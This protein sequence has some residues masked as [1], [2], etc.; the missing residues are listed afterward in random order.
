[1]SRPIAFVKRLVHRAPPLQE[2]ASV[3]RDDD[4]VLRE[5]ISLE[6]SVDRRRRTQSPS[7]WSGVRRESGEASIPSV[8]GWYISGS[9]ERVLYL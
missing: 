7:G 9:K 5:K 4:A 2:L 3:L 1:M 6:N 8:V